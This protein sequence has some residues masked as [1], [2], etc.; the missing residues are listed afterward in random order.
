MIHVGRRI[1]RLAAEEIARDHI[2]HHAIRFH[3]GAG[4]EGEETRRGEQEMCDV[5]EGHF[6]GARIPRITACDKRRVR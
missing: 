5:R 2:V 4:G 1:I 3:I 6:H